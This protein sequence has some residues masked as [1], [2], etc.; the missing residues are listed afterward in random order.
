MFLKNF[1]E[2]FLFKTIFIDKEA[3]IKDVIPEILKENYI[4]IDTEFTWRNT[5][6]PELDLI[7]ILAGK[8]IYIFDYLKMKKVNDLEKIF[9]NKNSIKVLH[10][11]RS[12]ISILSKTFDID[13]SNCRDTQ[14]AENII[15]NNFKDQISYKKLVQKYLNEE[16]EKSETNSNWQ[17]RPLNI[18]QLKYAANDVRYLV[19]IYL[20]L[21]KKLKIE[22]SFNEFLEKCEIENKISHKDYL[23]NRLKKFKAKNKSSSKTKEKI[24]LW[25][26]K[27]AQKL[28]IPPNKI[29]NDKFISNLEKAL[30]NNSPKEFNWIISDKFHR[31]DFIINFK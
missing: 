14:I 7:Q 18:N 29:C 20:K 12:D 16:I 19:K 22:N 4:G 11:L 24:F 27:L 1:K 13:I 3:H 10:S 6:F 30:R 17:K 2:K 5:Y 15:R 23:F 31:E 8:K 28:N 25:R 21:E 26:E 9:T